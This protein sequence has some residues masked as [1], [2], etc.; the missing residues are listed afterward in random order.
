M[1]RIHFRTASSPV[2]AKL[3]TPRRSA[4]QSSG[5]HLRTNVADWALVA[6]VASSLA[7]VLVV[8]GIRHYGPFSV[9][10]LRY[11][12]Q[13]DVEKF[14]FKLLEVLDSKESA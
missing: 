9:S 11:I 7:F 3:D 13:C 8:V 6:V 10:A 4:V 2:Q 1:V 14:K 5:I 12:L